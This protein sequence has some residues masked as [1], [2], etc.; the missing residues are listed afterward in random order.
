M[1]FTLHLRAYHANPIGG[2]LSQCQHRQI[3]TYPL[4]LTFPNHVML[5]HKAINFH[6]FQSFAPNN[7]LICAS[8]L[9]IKIYRLDHIILCTQETRLHFLASHGVTPK[10]EAN[11]TPWVPLLVPQTYTCTKRT[12]WV[13]PFFWVCVLNF[14]WGPFCLAGF[15]GPCGAGGQSIHPIPLNYL[16]N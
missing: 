9:I 12:T 1:D 10:H 16:P 6:I 3:N 11:N 7:L 5:L 4:Q 2:T 15:E 14:V 13:F 8:L